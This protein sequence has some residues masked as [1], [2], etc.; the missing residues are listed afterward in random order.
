MGQGA[1]GIHEVLSAKDIVEKTMAEAEE[2]L[3][4]LK[5]FG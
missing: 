3:E 1:G 5:K 4:R 2:V